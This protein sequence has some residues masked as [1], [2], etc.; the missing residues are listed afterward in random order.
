LKDPV[1]NVQQ[2]NLN[3]VLSYVARR[4]YELIV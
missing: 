1:A 2:K 4:P 3:E